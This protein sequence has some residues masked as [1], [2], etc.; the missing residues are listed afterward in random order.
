MAAPK[1]VGARQAARALAAGKAAALLVAEDASPALT[2]PLVA[3]AEAGGLPVFRVE[4]ME[5]L[6]RFCRIHVGAAVAAVLQ[7]D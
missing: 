6:G 7:E 4:T 5:E 2:A 1:Q 3:K